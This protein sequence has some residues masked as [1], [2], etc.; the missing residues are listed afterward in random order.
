MSKARQSS[1]GKAAKAATDQAAA[2]ENGV[3]PT[4]ITL[5]NGIVLAL[6]PIPPGIVERAMDRLEKPKVPKVMLKD[7]G[8]EEENP[9]DPEY[10]AALEAYQ[11]LRTETATNAMLLVGT[12]VKEIPEGLFG[13]EDTVGWLPDAA[14]MKHLGIV[15]ETSNKFDRYLSWLVLYAMARQG[16]ILAVMLVV[17]RVAGI[18]EEDVQA[19]VASF[20]NRAARRADRDVPAEAP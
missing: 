20:R 2:Q 5:S 18:G 11:A 9:G 6:K 10:V 1:R 15:A 14:L 17:N 3:L 12:A 8:V 19:A 4:E 16:D 13:P 7:K